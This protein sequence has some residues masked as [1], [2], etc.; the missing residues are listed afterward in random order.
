MEYIVQEFTKEFGWCLF[1]VCGCNEEHANNVL[2]TLQ[3]QYP[4][5][6]LRLAKVE[7]KD[8]WWNDPFLAN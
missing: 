5:K 1:T 6:K 4:E 7:S 8:C 2:I 3:K